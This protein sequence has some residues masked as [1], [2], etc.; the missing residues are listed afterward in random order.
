MIDQE[1]M[2]QDLARLRDTVAKAAD[3]LKLPLLREELAE[4]KADAITATVDLSSVTETGSCRVPVTVTVS[5][6][7]D[8]AVKGSYEVTVYIT[9]TEPA[10]VPLSQRMTR[11]RRC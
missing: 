11:A 9:D 10:P 8:V 2:K 1:R 4:L 6:Y 3:A 5:G 7:R